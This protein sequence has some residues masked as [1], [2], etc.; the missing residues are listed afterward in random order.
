M[1]ARCSRGDSFPQ[2]QIH[3][4]MTVAPLTQAHRPSLGCRTLAPVV[5]IEQETIGYATAEKVPGAVR[6]FLA[7]RQSA[8]AAKPTVGAPTSHNGGAE[9][10]VCLDSC[11]LA[12]GTD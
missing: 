11:C 6:D 5:R 12:K 2:P 1:V 3:R 4:P 9:I 7:S 10:K 8:V